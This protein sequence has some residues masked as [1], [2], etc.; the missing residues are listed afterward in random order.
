[1]IVHIQ[2]EFLWHGVRGQKLCWV[3][4]RKVC[5]PKIKGGL[6][7]KNVKLFNLSLLA[8][9]KW[10]L[11]SNDQSLWKRLFMDKYG[12]VKIVGWDCVMRHVQGWR[13]MWFTGRNIIQLVQRWGG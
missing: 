9:W 2:R 4:W 12:R 10:R 11:I 5:H 3:S 8:K 6:G 13:H 7:V 1:M